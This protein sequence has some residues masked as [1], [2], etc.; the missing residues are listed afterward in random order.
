MLS[1]CRPARQWKNL[2]GGGGLDAAEFTDESVA[3][4]V[5]W[6][7]QAAGKLFDQIELASLIQAVV[8]TDDPRSAAEPIAARTSP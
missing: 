8:V 6:V 2:K 3:Q 7:R 1:V 4:K 5:D